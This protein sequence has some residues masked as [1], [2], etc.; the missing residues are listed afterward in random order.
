M[1]TLSKCLAG[2]VLTLLFLLPLF[3]WISAEPVRYEDAEGHFTIL[4]PQ[5]WKTDDSGH[6]GP[7]VIMKGPAG[8]SGVEPV[9]HLTHEPTGI[10]TLDVMWHT[11]L[12]RIRYDLE[13]VQFKGLEDFEEHD[14]PYYQAR[15]SFTA[16]ESTQEAF[17]R[18]V[19]IGERFYLLTAT[20]T[21]G[22]FEQ[23]DKLFNEIF[24]SLRPG[25]KG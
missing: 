13:R 8:P 18:M 21:E 11:H 17:A 20:A 1:K 19:R 14:P 10:V 2:V 9:I 15:Y 23:L 24:D 3:S 25:K 6:M 7:G 5:G 12:G 16:G 4:S 22:E